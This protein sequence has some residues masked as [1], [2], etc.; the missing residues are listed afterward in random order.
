[1]PA[2]P[3]NPMPHFP[4]RTACPRRLRLAA[5]LAALLLVPALPVAADD[6]A[7]GRIDAA[8]VASARPLTE[9][10]QRVADDYGGSL[11]AIDLEKEAIEGASVLIYEAKVLTPKGHVLILAY[12]ARSLELLRQKGLD[13]EGR[14]RR[15]PGRRLGH[16]KGPGDGHGRGRGR[17]RGGEPDND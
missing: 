10:I 13:D 8:E 1:M 16:G 9:V 14:E 17:G 12:D 4:I 2:K 6:D 3:A 5:L 15:G 7:H 11:L